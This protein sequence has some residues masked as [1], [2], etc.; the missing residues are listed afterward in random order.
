MF[1]CSDVDVDAVFGCSDVEVDAVCGEWSAVF[2]RSAAELEIAAMPV[3]SV[4]LYVL[5]ILPA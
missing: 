2:S 1:G 3:L 4:V 5:S